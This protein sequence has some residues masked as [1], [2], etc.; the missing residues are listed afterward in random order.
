MHNRWPYIRD[1]E[2]VVEGE[3]SLENLQGGDLMGYRIEHPT[4]MG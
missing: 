4:E 3:T 1:G 2:R